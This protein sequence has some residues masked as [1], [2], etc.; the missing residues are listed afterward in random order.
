MKR[1]RGFTV[2]EIMLAL[3]IGSTLLALITIG[4]N[5]TL[6]RRGLNTASMELEG[7]LRNARQAAPNAAGG[8]RILFQEATPTTKGSWQVL[9]GT[10]TTHQREMDRDLQITLSPPTPAWIEFSGS[11]TLPADRQVTLSSSATNDSIRWKLHASTGAI[12]RL[13]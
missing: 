8:A 9:V 7:A 5:R 4:G 2:I 12:E 11:G 13:P 1:D 6:A 10:Q 3:L